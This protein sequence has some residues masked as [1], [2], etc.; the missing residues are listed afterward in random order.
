MRSV[1]GWLV[2]ASLVEWALAGVLGWVHSIT[3]LSH[4]SQ[5]TFSAALVPWY[6]GLRV[7]ARQVDEDVPGEVV[8]RIVEETDVEEV[9]SADQA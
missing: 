2:V 5:F 3:Y 4:L 6:Q 8:T 9:G 1:T 7:E